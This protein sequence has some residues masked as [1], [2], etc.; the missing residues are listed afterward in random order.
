MS[1]VYGY[2]KV[3]VNKNGI[4]GVNIFIPT[5]SGETLLKLLEEKGE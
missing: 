4:K 2:A 1:P 5:E 3:I